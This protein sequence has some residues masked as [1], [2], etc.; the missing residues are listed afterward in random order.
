MLQEPGTHWGPSSGCLWSE[1]LIQKIHVE[2]VDVN[3][4]DV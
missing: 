4:K 1:L 2:M 3:D